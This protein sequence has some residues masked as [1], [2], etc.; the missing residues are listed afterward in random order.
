[1]DCKTILESMGYKV[2]EIGKY[3]YKVILGSIEMTLYVQ[4][5]GFDGEGFL[6]VQFGRTSTDGIWDIFEQRMV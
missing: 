6:Y 2:L 1:M 5:I 3:L 4:D